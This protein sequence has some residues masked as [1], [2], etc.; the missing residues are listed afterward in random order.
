MVFRTDI[1]Q[2]L[3]LGAPGYSQAV[4]NNFLWEGVADGKD[5]FPDLVT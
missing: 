4:P 1:F 3:A 2:K 5:F